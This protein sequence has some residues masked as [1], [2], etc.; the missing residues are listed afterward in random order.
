MADTPRQEAFL[1]VLGSEQS[2]L[3]VGAKATVSRASMRTTL[4]VMALSSSLL[5]M[6]FAAQSWEILFPSSPPSCSLSSSWASS[7]RCGWSMLPWRT[8][9]SSPV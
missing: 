9:T 1:V 5:A 4:S 7:R 6:G 8:T 2:V 3:Q